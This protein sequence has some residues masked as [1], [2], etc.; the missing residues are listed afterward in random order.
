MVMLTLALLLQIAM[1]TIA[2]ETYI[3]AVNLAPATIIGILTG[4]SLSKYLTEE[5]FRQI[6]LIVLAATVILLLW[7]LL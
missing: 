1:V 4:R 2:T 6:L 3:S 7:T 5:T